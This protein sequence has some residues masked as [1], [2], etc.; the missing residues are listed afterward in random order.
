[1][2]PNRDS[3]PLFESAVETQSSPIVFLTNR[4]N[5][6]QIL[7][8]SYI[9]PKESYSKYYEDMLAL[10]PGR[11]PLVRSPVSKELQALVLREGEATFPV[12]LEIAAEQVV[13]GKLPSLRS[14]GTISKSSLAD[15][16]TVAWAPSG[17]IPISMIRRIIFRSKA[18]LAEHTARSYDNISEAVLPMDVD[19]SVFNG[20]TVSAERVAG[21]LKELP[22][23]GSDAKAYVRADRIAGARGLATISLAHAPDAATTVMQL[24]SSATDKDRGKASPVAEKRVAPWIVSLTAGSPVRA[25]VG[26]LNTRL[27]T[28]VAQVFEAT[29]RR[30]EWRPIEM[31]ARLE[32]NVQ[33][34]K[35]SKKDAVEIAKNFE[36]IRG[37]L[38]NERDFKPFT[39]GVGLDVAKALLLVLL[40]PDAENLLAWPAS[41]TGAD[42][43]VTI[44]AAALCGLLNGR[45][46]LPVRLRPEKLDRFLALTVAS[47]LSTGKD[48]VQLTR[49]RDRDELTIERIPGEGASARLSLMWNGDSLAGWDERPAGS[50]DRLAGLDLD[51]PETERVAL[52]LCNRLAWNDCVRTQVTLDTAEV[53]VSAQPKGKTVIAFRGLLGS[54]TQKLDSA[55]F[56][57]RISNGEISRE[58]EA[59]LLSLLS[60]GSAPIR[61]V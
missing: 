6:L 30:A 32:S 4:Y 56:K 58:D 49:P 15:D 17:V 52:E 60:K 47:E 35:L 51:Q 9:A 22:R 16:R 39:P 33:A 43:S 54:V 8:A 34:K 44:T 45:E 3:A 1:M 29:D 13:D 20:G 14:D 50:K 21:W 36:S 19:P 46:R 31:V 10:G 11:V 37:I 25:G 38:R 40:R 42:D 2:T 59:K 61:V 23:D 41:E 27:F 57:K 5:L 53:S 28:A 26:D 48:S 55:A 18:D 12:A 24:L 7:S